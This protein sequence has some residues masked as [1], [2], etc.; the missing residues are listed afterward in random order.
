M[1]PA[2]RTNKELF[3]KF[4]GLPCETPGPPSVDRHG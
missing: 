2:A 3:D 4:V 1:A